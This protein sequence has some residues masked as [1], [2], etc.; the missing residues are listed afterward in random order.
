MQ[1][2]HIPFTSL[3]DMFERIHIPLVEGWEEESK[4]L[5]EEDDALEEAS[6]NEEVCEEDFSRTSTI[7]ENITKQLKGVNSYL[8]CWRR[9]ADS[10]RRIEVLQFPILCVLYLSR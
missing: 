8:N 3:D 7:T 6:E 4:R 2:P 9:R 10:N 5:L 1:R